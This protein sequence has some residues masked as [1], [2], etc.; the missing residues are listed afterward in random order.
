MDRMD[1]RLDTFDARQYEIAQT[2]A[3][4]E[5]TQQTMLGALA[6]IEQGTRP[7]SEPPTQQTL[8]AAAAAPED[9]PQQSVTASTPTPT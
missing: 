5:A 4:L 1:A 2:V 3:R 9:E 6:R 8:F 7:A